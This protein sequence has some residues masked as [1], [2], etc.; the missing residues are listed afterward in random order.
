MLSL[1]S[2]KSSLAASVKSVALSTA[3]SF[4]LA[5]ASPAESIFSA[6]ASFK[7]PAL[8]ATASFIPDNLLIQFYYPS[9]KPRE[10]QLEILGDNAIYRE[11][12]KV[13]H[14]WNEKLISYSEINQPF[15][16]IGRIRIWPSDDLP[17]RLIFTWLDLVSF[18]KNFPSKKV[19]CI[20]WDLDNTLWDGVIGDDGADNVLPNYELISLIKEFD[21]RGILQSIIS[22]NDFELAWSKI[23][24][25]GLDHYF[26]YPAIH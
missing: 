24:D 14:G 1:A 11:C 6:A 22:K 4:A 21:N 17:M 23:Q 13:E 12:I 3:A 5:K 9:S 16:G 19:K 25:L 18:N 7:S 20:C 2:V 26:L 10:L 15:D 8:S